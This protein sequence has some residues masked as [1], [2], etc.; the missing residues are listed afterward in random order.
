MLQNFLQTAFRNFRHNSLYTTLNLAGL[1]VGFAGFLLLGLYIT[2]ELRFDARHTKA[3]RIYR[4]I[5]EKT[6]ADG[7]TTRVAATSYLAAERS[8]Q[9]LPE[10]A[11]VVKLGLMG[12]SNVYVSDAKQAFHERIWHAD[13]SFA[14]LFDFQWLSGDAGTAFAAPYSVVLSSNLARRLFGTDQVLGRTVHIGQFG[15]QQ[16]LTVTGVLEDFPKNSS[17]YF[18]CAVSTSTFDTNN[19]MK[20]AR[21]SDWTSNNFPTWFLLQPD[22]N[23]ASVETK[24]NRLIAA[25]TP[26]GQTEKRHY[27]LLAIRDIH[28]KGAG[29]DGLSDRMANSAYVTVLSLV[30]LFLLGIACINYINL[31]TARAAGRSR[32]VGVRK[33]VGA[34]QGHMIGQFLTET[35]LLVAAAFLLAVGLL[36][37]VLPGFNEFAGK[38]LILDTATDPMIWAGAGGAALLVG[39][40]AGLYPAMYLARLR[41]TVLFKNVL[42]GNWWEFSLRKALV[43]AQF[44]LSA[45]LM[46]CTG[47]V[48]RQMRFLENKDLGFTREQLVVVDI[49][50]QEVRRDFET[51]K[52]GYAQ[53]PGVEAV[54][55]TSRVPGEWKN[56][57]LI[58]VGR[59]GTDAN[60]ETKTASLILADEDFLKTYQVPLLSGRNFASN[61]TD[62]T[63]VILNESA[64][65]LLGIT[66]PGE[67][68]IDIPSVSFSGTDYPLEQ[69]F[70]AQVVGIVRD[71]H[72]RSLHE[73]IGPLVL[74]TRRNPI[75]IIDYFTVRL[76]ASTAQTVLPRLESVLRATDPD[77]Q[78]EWHFL[79]E[80]WALFYQEDARR[81]KILTAA[82]AG[83]IFIACLGLFGLATFAAERRRKEIGIRKVL[84]A[85]LG[86]I[87]SLLTRDFLKL[88]VIAILL[89]SP[90]AWWVM[91]KW[92]ADFAYR[93]DIQWWMFGAAG[94]VAM[95][96][97]F[98][99]VGFQSLKAAL[100][101]P[102]KSLRS[103]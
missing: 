71:F 86:N 3:D 22:A 49:N 12:R 100:A 60:T 7:K 26:P 85:G 87:T 76:Q 11:D 44:G 16:T 43:V 62:S 89:A 73:K 33:V 2:D 81:Q 68:R 1:T 83:A 51:V 23:A 36:Q 35:Y 57:P 99:T 28:F 39:L 90:I 46:I 10:I 59:E 5:E 14:Q 75:H 34:S 64:A 67:Q 92:L 74:A 65:A 78:F 25:N 37:L 61:D 98:L 4:L 13:S 101:N 66:E 38:A 41:P 97:A 40:L 29:I 32:E 55:V 77:H 69:T 58:A 53:I 30:A 42:P 52:A 31:T 94:L 102:V 56:L 93:I 72:F 95:L 24:I 96:I 84:G 50:S 21:A 47:V 80:Q 19:S 91:Q 70:K 45:L 9:D 20:E 103:E 54:S 63:A 8:R 6:D 18:D 17:I 82:A 79:N 88:V 15:P 48:W 27:S